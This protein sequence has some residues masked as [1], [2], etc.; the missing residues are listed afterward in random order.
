MS[1]GPSSENTTS[2]NQYTFGDLLLVQSLSYSR[3]GDNETIRM[4]DDYNYEA[5]RLISRVE[6]DLDSGRTRTFTYTYE[7]DLIS[8]IQIHNG[9]DELESEIKIYYNDNNQVYSYEYIDDLNTNYSTY[10]LATLSYENNQ[11]LLCDGKSWSS[12]EYKDVYDS[13][14]VY[15]TN[16]DGNI[17]QINEI[18][19]CYFSAPSINGGIELSLEYDDNPS[20]FINITGNNQILNT[21]ITPFTGSITAGFSNNATNQTG[22]Q[23]QEW[24][25]TYNNAGY[26]N[27]I[28]W[29]SNNAREDV[30]VVYY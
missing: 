30:E 16:D 23:A 6:T 26:P 1:C 9:N 29:Q 15:T 10:S 11:T 3:T 7:N 27:N 4:Q 18:D 2:E 13:V 21:I 19:D 24:V 8:D 5:E 28:Q 14:L 22:Y 17:V 20:P 12:V 25:Y